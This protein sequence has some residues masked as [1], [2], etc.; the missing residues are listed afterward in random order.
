MA[1]HQKNHISILQSDDPVG[2][3]LR[4]FKVMAVHKNRDA[5]LFLNLL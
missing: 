3:L 5:V 4:K 2:K 1:F